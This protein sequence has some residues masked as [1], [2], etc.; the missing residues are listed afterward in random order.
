MFGVLAQILTVN[1]NPA[2]SWEASVM[3]AS[4]SRSVK[5][6]CAQKLAL[7]SG[8]ISSVDCGGAVLSGHLLT[9]FVTMILCSVFYPLAQLYLSLI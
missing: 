9:L 6:G 8:N 7:V 3:G 5:Y 1:V 4:C 2:E